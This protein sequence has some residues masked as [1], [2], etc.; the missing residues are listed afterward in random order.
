M[1][2]YAYIAYLFGGAFLANSIPHFVNGISGRKFPT[3]FA[4][5]P[6][7]GLSSPLLN[8]LWGFSNFAAGF[9]LLTAVGMFKLGITIDTFVTMLGALL[10][11]IRL[12]L[13]FG[14][15]KLSH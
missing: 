8:V 12:A 3:P 10:M 15:V 13:H 7:K 4:H 9:L 2:L 5:P 1:A 14:S 6:G 11:S